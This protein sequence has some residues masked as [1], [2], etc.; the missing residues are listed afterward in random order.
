MAG[1]FV[2]ADLATMYDDD[3][4]A[5]SGTVSGTTVPGFFD[6]EYVRGLDMVSG[7]NPVFRIK[8]TDTVAAVGSTIA[9]AGTNY[10]IRDREPLDD[11]AE[12]LLQ[13]EKQ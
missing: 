11:G 5:V 10:T 7:A 4:L 9:I 13:L 3:E 1:T 6:R 12:V 8:A 2:T